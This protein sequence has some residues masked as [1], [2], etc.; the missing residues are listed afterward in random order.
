M[1]N[2]VI[3]RAD[4]NSN[5][6]LGHIMRCLSLAEILRPSFKCIFV[7]QTESIALHKLISNYAELVTLSSD[8][9]IDQLREISQ[10]VLPTDLVV[11]DGYNFSGAYIQFLKQKSMGLILIDDLAQG[12]FDCALVINHASKE[13]SSY[14]NLLNKTK[15]LCGFDFLILRKEFL[16]LAKEQRKITE[17]ETAFICMGGADPS[18]T[19][20]KVLDACIVTGL[21]KT[22]NVVVGSAYT[23]KGELEELIANR[24]ENLVVNCFININANEL[25]KLVVASQVAICPSS[26]IALEVCCVKS[27][28]L[29]GRTADNQY[30]LHQ[31]LLNSRCASSIGDFTVA[32]KQTLVNALL[33]LANTSKVN[34]MMENQGKEIDGKSDKRILNAFKT[35]TSC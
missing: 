1:Q 3:F 16:A 12:N 21:F 2:R 7:I 24:K 19:T 18:N 30:Y 28:L 22:I 20:I 32:T 31:Q 6:G 33:D 13:I 23:N 9:E 29:T 17:I 11:L 34:K 35:L 26:T 14:Y 4:G 25:I 10:L 5:I 27:G 15:L 8:A